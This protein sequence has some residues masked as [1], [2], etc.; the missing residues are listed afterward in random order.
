[1]CMCT[2]GPLSESWG[3][4]L[5]SNSSSKFPAHRHLPQVDETGEE[6]SYHHEEEDPLHVVQA[7]SPA[8][9]STLTRVLPAA[10]GWCWNPSVA[11]HLLLRPPPGILPEVN[12][13]ILD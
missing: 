1:M 10:T 9:A 5:R 12:S 8:S 7:E 6:A 4:G 11:D 3:C 2:G 13:C